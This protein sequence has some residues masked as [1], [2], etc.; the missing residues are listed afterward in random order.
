MTGLEASLF[1]GKEGVDIVEANLELHETCLK[2]VQTSE[3]LKRRRAALDIGEWA[4][5]SRMKNDT[6]LR[7][8]MNACAIKQGIR[9]RL[10]QRKF[11]LERLERSYRQTVNSRSCAF[12]FSC[13]LLTKCR[14]ETAYSY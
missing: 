13:L 1:K 2:V 14:S 9:D 6:Y 5:L 4:M 11:E 12:T 3:A 10:R 7:V 8:K